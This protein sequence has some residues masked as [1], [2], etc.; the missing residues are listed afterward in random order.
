MSAMLLMVTSLRRHLVAVHRTGCLTNDGMALVP[1]FSTSIIIY[2][3]CH[4]Y[5][6]VSSLGGAFDFV[7]QLWSF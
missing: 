6:F 2:F 7:K 1:V 4:C 3:S 5:P